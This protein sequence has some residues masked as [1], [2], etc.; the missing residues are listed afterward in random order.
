MQKQL[1]GLLLISA[2]IAGTVNADCNSSTTDSCHCEAT[3]RSY[4]GIRPQGQSVSP[5]YLA[6][7]RN[8][9]L[10]AKEDGWGGAIQAVLFGGRT[11]KSKDLDRYFLPFCKEAIISSDEAPA[12][13]VIRDVFA[14]DFNIYTTGNDFKSTVSFSPRQSTV[15]FLLHWRQAFWSNE[16]CGRGFWASISSP[17]IHVKN[18]IGFTEVVE[19]EGTLDPAIPNAVANMTQ[20]FKQTSWLY[21]R[22]DD[23]SQ[24][25]TRLADIEIKLGYE[26]LQHDPCHL[27]SYVGIVIPTGNKPKAEFMFEPIVGNGKHFGVMWGS[28][29]GINIW[30]D[31]CNDRNMRMEFAVHSQYLFKRE[32]KR[33]FDL[34]GKPWSRFLPVYAS[35]EDALAA[36]DADTNDVTINTTPGVNVF[37]RCVNVTPGYSIN[38]TS[39]L[40]FETCNFNAELGYNFYARRSE[41]VKLADA[42][43]STIAL[44]NITGAGETN[45]IR[46][47]TGNVFLEDGVI[48]G[49]LPVT[50]A[51]YANSIIKES[52]LDLVSAA[53]PC[54]ISSTI[55]GS[56]GYDFE[57]LCDYPAFAN[58]G[59]SYEF[60]NTNNG[61]INR[62]TL[63]GK[64][65]VSF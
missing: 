52:D 13:G 46:D 8:N 37:T 40:V 53:T 17:L 47:I 38:M 64:I 11:T 22:I 16:E 57:S 14:E 54:G 28:A 23:C 50:A 7:F 25:K 9:R 61:M 42:F 36:L 58:L 27:E 1:L 65:G 32:Q 4:L 51:N 6:G 19:T 59:G 29:Y 21:S 39:A 30:Q 5:E 55:Y 45:P 12:V 43:P 2:S 31:S 48:A 20:A 35:Q 10:H 24:S 44:T 26:W 41:C 56:I 62:W 49:I 3:S 33:S 60:A 63:W 15:G 34:K 18:S